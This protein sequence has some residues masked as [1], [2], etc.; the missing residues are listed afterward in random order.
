M[1]G[2]ISEAVGRGGVLRVEVLGVGAADRAVAGTAP[3]RRRRSSTV[4]ERRG[5]PGSAL[6]LR[7]RAAPAPSPR[8]PGLTPGDARRLARDARRRPGRRRRGR[9]SPVGS[10]GARPGTCGRAPPGR[11][12]TRACR[13]TA[14]SATGRCS[15]P[16]MPQGEHARA[17]RRWRARRAPVGGDRR[18]DPGPEAGARRVGRGRRRD[19]R[20]EQ[21]AAEQ[22][23]RGRQ[24]DEGEDDR[25]DDAR[26]RRPDPM[27]RSKG[28]RRAP[29]VEQAER[30]GARSWPG[31][32]ARP[33]PARRASPRGGPR[34]RRSSSR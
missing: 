25:G 7:R 34:W 31:S 13:G 3:G 32:P 2:T 29:S 18:A 16:S 24:Q 4:R 26:S 28:S 33:C 19:E 5:V 22:Q 11:R 17:A 27:L 15:A 10:T 23:Q 30:H 12:P 6:Q 21:P 20:P 8:A 1:S 9:R 14:R